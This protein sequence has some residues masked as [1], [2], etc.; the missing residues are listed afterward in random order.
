[1][2]KRIPGSKNNTILNKIQFSLRNTKLSNS[3][4]KFT[5]SFR[6]S[7]KTS[8][9]I[10]KVSIPK[11]TLPK[12][13]RG[14]IIISA[15]ILVIVLIGYGF[16]V[17][18]SVNPKGYDTQESAMYKKKTFDNTINVLY[19]GF[20][21]R[22]NSYKYIKYLNIVSVDSKNSV[23][24]IY[25]ISPNFLTTINNDSVTLE[26]LWNNITIE[27]NTP[28]INVV[29]D[30]IQRFVGIRLDRY[31]AFNLDDLKAY[32]NT[33]R[34][35]D[36]AF[37]TS[38]L[39]GI[40]F[41]KGDVLSGD[42]LYGYLFDKTQER[43]I[44]TLR[45]MNFQKSLFEGI[46]GPIKMTRNLIGFSDFNSTFKMDFSRDEYSSFLTNLN[47]SDIIL[48]STHFISDKFGIA[49][50][51]PLDT[52][53]SPDYN[54][55]DENVNAYFRD[56]DIMKE[57]AAVEVYNAT[58]TA[59]LA[60]NRRRFFQNLGANVVK[61]G[62]YPVSDVQSS[63]LYVPSKNVDLYKNNIIMIQKLL[64]GN[65]KITFEEYKYNY[66]GDLILVMG[67]DTESI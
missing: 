26:S 16:S 56:I 7:K 17:Y 9:P 12:N 38:S 44:I 21:N 65:V 51:D 33:S 2:T 57:Q 20:E 41:T 60:G 40:L 8:L 34:M 43:D 27:D 31:I 49:S 52:S 53:V 29:V 62:N 5:R 14:Y 66:S 15:V 11:I 39:D 30:E 32:V 67:K 59:G 54:L 23:F 50:V 42:F 3:I 61:F 63:L 24:K 6:S 45:Q 4:I 64:R 13:S 46:K 55:I 10:G 37:D 36:T 19:I 48:S 35:T 58:D 1:M 25:G 18:F 47:S 28:R 22:L